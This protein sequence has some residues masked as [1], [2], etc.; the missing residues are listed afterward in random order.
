MLYI[1]S[2]WTRNSED[3]KT[4]EIVCGIRYNLRSRAMHLLGDWGRVMHIG[5]CLSCTVNE[6]CTY[7]VI[8]PGSQCSFC[9]SSTYLIIRTPSVRLSVN[10]AYFRPFFPNPNLASSILA[11]RVGFEIV[12]MKGYARFKFQRDIIKKKENIEGD[13]LKIPLVKNHYARKDE[14]LCQTFLI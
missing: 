9:T 3:P 12:Q 5:H 2:E 6:Q 1:S 8:T 13:K 7:I 14:T 10:V 4:E 11:W